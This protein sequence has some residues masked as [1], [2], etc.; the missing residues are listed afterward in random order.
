MGVFRISN[1][2]Y[3]LNPS[4]LRYTFLSPR[5]KTL[6]SST[7]VPASDSAYFVISSSEHRSFALFIS[8]IAAKS[9][10]SS[11]LPCGCGSSVKLAKSFSVPNVSFL[12]NQRKLLSFSSS[13]NTIRT[14]D[15]DGHSEHC[16]IGVSSTDFY[17]IIDIIKSDGSDL[18]SRLGDAGSKLPKRSVIEILRVLN[19][20]KVPAMR[21]FE[22]VRDMHPN[23]SRNADICSLMVDNC[24]RLGDY[25]TMIRLLKD[26]RAAKICLTDQAFGFLPILS[27]TKERAKKSIRGIIKVLDEV[28]G[29]CRNSG[30]HSLLELLCSLN[31][32][33][34]ANFVLEITE[35]KVS[36]Y[37]ILVKHFCVRGQFEHAKNMLEDMWQM[38]CGPEAKTYNFF[39]SS[40]CKQGRLD[41]AYSVLEEMLNRGCNPDEITYEIFIY[42]SCRYKRLDHAVEIYNQMVSSRVQPRLPTHYA[43][44]RG[45]FNSQQFDEAYKYVIDTAAK[46]PWSAEGIYNVL[47][48]LHLKDG[49]LLVARNILVEMIEKGLKPKY[50]LYLRVSKRL[51]KTG[52]EG[53]ATDLNTKFSSF[54]SKLRQNSR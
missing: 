52:K 4:Y 19:I 7:P 54:M 23:H 48:G 21:F 43:F 31:S 27:S 36:Y 38:R 53:F 6:S 47:A 37:N 18:E 46:H 12:G 13:I 8:S 29:S 22:W 3:P 33:D 24:G 11:I 40:L 49:N 35:R 45:Y 1:S 42:F 16:E 5:F 14:S 30:I 39:I 51:C 26:F 20:T 34:L 28:G 25:A 32:F 9:F 50:L 15:E 44:I 2:R 10:L 17:R 41:E